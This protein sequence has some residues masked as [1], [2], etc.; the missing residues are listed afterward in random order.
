MTKELKRGKPGRKPIADKKM[1]IT[2]YR[3]SSE[4]K[5]LGGVDKARQL[6]HKHID[7]LIKS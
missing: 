2:I 7:S 4:T 1:P 3:S 6:L 5:A